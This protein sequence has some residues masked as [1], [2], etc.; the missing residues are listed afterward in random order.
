MTIL[1]T[2]RGLFATCLMITLL[3]CKLNAQPS[4]SASGAELEEVYV[5]GSRTR[6][7]QDDAISPLLSLSQDDLHLATAPLLADAL[8][9]LPQAGAPLTS[10]TTTNFALFAPGIASVDLRNLSPNRTLV[11]V[12]GRRH[13]GGDSERPN[14]VDLNS[15]PDALI[16][17][18]DVVTGGVS[19]V[20]GS[21]AVAGVINIITKQDVEGVSLDTQWGQSSEGDGTEKTLSLTAGTNFNNSPVHLT[22]NASY[23]DVGEVYSRDRAFSANDEYLGDF[24]DY[25][26]WAPQGAVLPPDFSAMITENDAGAWTKD[27]VVAEDGFNRANHRLLRVPLT[28]ESALVNVDYQLSA[29]SNIFFEGSFVKTDSQSRAEPVISGVFGYADLN[30]HVLPT[31]NPFIPAEALTLL[32]AAYG[33]PPEFVLFTRRMSELGERVSEQERETKRIAAGFSTELGAWEL[34]GYYQWGTSTRQQRSFGHYNTSAFQQG[35][36]VE[37]D[38][39]NAGQFRCIDATARAEGCVPI[40]V[41]GAGSISPAAV[42]YIAIDSFDSSKITQKVA[43]ASMR[44]KLPNPLP[45]QDIRL[46]FGLEWR[47][48]QLNTNADPFALAGISSSNNITAAIQGEYEVSEAFVEFNL[49]IA[50]V[51]STDFAYRLADYD[52][53]GTHGSWHV[54]ADFTPDDLVSFRLMRASS[55]RAPNV[56]ELYDP[57]TFTFTPILDPCTNGGSGRPGSTADN[58]ASLGIPGDFDPGFAG[59]EAPGLVAGN[60]NLDEETADTRTAGIQIRPTPSLAISWDYFD[61]SVKDAIE[62]MDPQYKLNQCYAAANF[63][64]SAFCDGIVRDDANANYL[65]SRLDFGLQNIGRLETSGWDLALH[66]TP[67]WLGVQWGINANV[68]HT[69]KWQSTVLGNDS[70]RLEEPGF[71]EWKANSQV[72]ATRDALSVSWATRYLGRGVV[73]N[74]FDTSIWPAND[75]LPSV[76]YHDVKLSYTVDG[77]NTNYKFYLGVNNAFDKQPPYI[78]SPSVN[79]NAGTNTAA[80]V[81]DV[82]GRFMYLGA[83]VAF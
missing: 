58:C 39:D 5:T 10:Q 35:L 79:N 12:N 70:T 25:S 52:S 53:V 54:G 60:V 17:R 1:T 3:P 71:Q 14:V 75:A 34:D 46:A 73:D 41:F 57:G 55:V 36:D 26:Q 40:N 7:L 47:E 21:E 9:R 8:N 4:E 44:G 76:T 24:Q 45:A 49:P 28:R 80:G 61:I 64:N 69:I 15:I 66:Y 59:G 42:N 67:Q 32:T 37:P 63:P 29:K 82:V 18:V 13:V 2:G 19:A 65:I 81:Y 56:A 50:D 20:Y 22:V 74:N 11:L 23:T 6:T 43:A 48:E 33:G 31:D 27:F 72:S 62:F 51:L 38:P 83:S 78:P 16:E 68:T 77:E 30:S